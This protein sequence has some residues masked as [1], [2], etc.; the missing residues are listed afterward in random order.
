MADG[1]ARGT[2]ASSVRRSVAGP[3]LHSP[4]RSSALVPPGLAAP[5]D[6]PADGAGNAKQLVGVSIPAEGVGGGRGSTG[7]DGVRSSRGQRAPVSG[8]QAPKTPPPK[9]TLAFSP[10]TLGE[11]FTYR[12]EAVARG[13]AAG[14]Q[15][16]VSAAPARPAGSATARSARSDPKNTVAGTATALFQGEET[17]AGDAQL[18][19][20]RSEVT[21][22][23]QALQEQQSDVLGELAALQAHNTALEDKLDQVLSFM[24]RLAPESPQIGRAHV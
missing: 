3:V 6:V 20:L 13:S 22:D 1:P 21:G 8:L 24:R 9:D 11:A 16:A 4:A 2:R 5:D 19:A 14:R 18:I 23:I 7:R 12:D 15:Q 10:L 17:V